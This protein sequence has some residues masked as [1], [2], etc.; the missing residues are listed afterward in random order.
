M[1][2][3]YNDYMKTVRIFVKKRRYEILYDSYFH[4]PKRFIFN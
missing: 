4:K 1:S 3:F 2:V